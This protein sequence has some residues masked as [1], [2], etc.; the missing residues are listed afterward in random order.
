MTQTILSG[1]F[2]G[3][4]ATLF[5]ISFV[6]QAA[7]LFTRDPTKADKRNVWLYILWAPI[8]W[9]RIG[10]IPLWMFFST[11]PKYNI[12]LLVR[13]RIPGSDYSPWRL[14]SHSCDPRMKWCWNPDLRRH[15]S[16]QDFAGGLLNVISK[17]SSIAGEEL[18]ASVP[19][20]GLATYAA[21]LPRTP[22]TC[23]RQFMI[24]RYF[25]LDSR[26]PEVLFISPELAAASEQE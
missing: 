8:L 1:L 12:R 24:C 10:F 17:N 4:I 21:G 23:G 22:F 3:L 9:D 6:G 15:K 20:R 26:S 5:Y 11:P 18:F 14:I 16:M 19:F 25:S 7:R 13:E 2:L